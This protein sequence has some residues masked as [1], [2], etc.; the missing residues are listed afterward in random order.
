MSQHSH[1]FQQFFQLKIAPAYYWALKSAS[2]FFHIVVL[3]DQRKVCQ[4]KNN[5][6][7][8]KHSE[9]ILTLLIREVWVKLARIYPYIFLATLLKELTIKTGIVLLSCD[10]CVYHFL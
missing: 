10:S 5:F 6:I 7:I 9:I 2:T 1:S 4:I 8:W 3:P